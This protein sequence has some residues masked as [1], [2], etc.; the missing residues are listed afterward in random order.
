[1]KLLDMFHPCECLITHTVYSGL[2]QLEILNTPYT[3]Q[4]TNMKNT[5]KQLK[6]KNKV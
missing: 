5:V 4:Q 6:Q 2:D 1:M 3:S